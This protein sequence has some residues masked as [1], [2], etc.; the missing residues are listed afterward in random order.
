MSDRLN[1]PAW[2]VGLCRSQSK[3]VWRGLITEREAAVFLR[4]FHAAALTEALR[5]V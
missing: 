4:V 2:Y 3:A 1:M 5:A